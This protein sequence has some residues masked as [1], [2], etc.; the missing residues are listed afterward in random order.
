[1]PVV[2]AVPEVEIRRIVVTGHPDPI[3]HDN[4]S[5]KQQRKTDWRCGSILTVPAL[6]E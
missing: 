1:M 4:K 3:L 6:K 2:L 5:P